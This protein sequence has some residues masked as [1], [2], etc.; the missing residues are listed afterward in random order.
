MT[1][2][3]VSDENINLRA[4]VWLTSGQSV[5][6]DE[7]A[8]Y[9]ELAM[10]E[11]LGLR[12]QAAA[13]FAKAG[14]P[15]SMGVLGVPSL[16][17]AAEAGALM[18]VS[19]LIGKANFQSGL[20]LSNAAQQKFMELSSAPKWFVVTSIRNMASP[21]PA[22]WFAED[23]SHEELISLVQL[24]RDERE[25]FLKRYGKTKTDIWDNHIRVRMPV[26]YVHNADEF[27]GVRSEG[28]L[29]N[30]RWPQVASYL[31]PITSIPHRP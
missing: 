16:A 2:N 30:V 13:A 18:L 12:A 8:L 4:T 25:D 1:E 29:M 6:I 23:G 19:G 15:A 26:R 3:P 21:Y 31:P 24:N 10:K 27:V 9:D 28:H 14:A 20:Q 11:I 17:F 7:I 22:S 5:H